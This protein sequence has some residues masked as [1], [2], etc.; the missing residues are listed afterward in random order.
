[1]TEQKKNG[2]RVGFARVEAMPDGPI[3]LS[4]FSNEIQRVSQNALDTLYTQCVAVSDGQD[5][6]ALIITLDLVS[7]ITMAQ[8]ATDRIV[9]A[10]GVPRENIYMNATH[11]HSGPSM[12]KGTGYEEYTV[13]LANKVVEAAVAAMADRSPATM[14][15]GRADTEGLNFVKHY[16][17]DNGTYAGDNHGDFRSGKIVDHAGPNDPEIRV[18]KIDREDKKSILLA[19]WQAHAMLTSAIDKFDLSADFPA[20]TREA[21]EARVQDCYFVYLQGCSGDLNPRTYI[22]SEYYP[23]DYKVFGQILA[24]YAIQAMQKLQ[25]VGGDTVKTK[26]V[27]YT[28]Q[29]NHSQDHLSE[30]GKEVWALF[31]SNGDRKTAT[32]LARSYGFH[33]VYHAGM[34]IGRPKIGPTM[35]VEL[36]TIALGDLAIATT[37]VEYFNQLGVYVR[38]NSPYD[39]TLTLSYTNDRQGYM[40]SSRA[41]EY[42]CYEADITFYAKGTGEQ[43][44]D[45][46]VS[47]LKEMKDN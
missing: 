40:P 7:P 2:L 18:V 8:H 47:M 9:E 32:K 15:A 38:K 24:H 22:A 25:S 41:Y 6:T 19:N 31:Q 35:E 29:V 10:T 43:V 44:A 27:I 16:L 34:M 21:F 36:N 42:G 12:L 39:M 5:N 4:G 11:T 14:A 13:K 20:S 3:S 28:V 45:Q 30:Y 37:P 17:L 46:L 23:K 26:R 1:M 33:S